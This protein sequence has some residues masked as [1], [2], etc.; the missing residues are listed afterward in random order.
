MRTWVEVCVKIDRMRK[1]EMFV[2]LWINSKN[3][4]YLSWIKIWVFDILLLHT[5]RLRRAHSRSGTHT[6]AQALT[7]PHVP[8]Q[9][10]QR[11]KYKSGYLCFHLI[12][13]ILWVTPAYV[14]A[15]SCTRPHL[16]ACITFVHINGRMEKSKFLM[17]NF[18]RI[19]G[20]YFM[21]SWQFELSNQSR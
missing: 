15:H 13:D 3:I 19:V 2:F 5:L 11:E 18:K 21:G 4:M 6:P 10:Y 14:R 12:Y 7:L 9:T 8:L 20:I 17:H 1:T 16:R